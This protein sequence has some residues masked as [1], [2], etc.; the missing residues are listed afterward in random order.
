MNKSSNRPLSLSK[1]IRAFS[2][3]LIAIGLLGTS[4]SA[5][6]AIGENLGTVSNSGQLGFSLAVPNRETPIAA[7]QLP[8][9]P[10]S[11]GLIHLLSPYRQPNSDYSAGHRGVDYRAPLA[12]QVFSPSDGLIAFAGQVATRKLVTIKHDANLVT[13]FEPVCSQVDVGTEVRKGDPI[14]AI[15]NDLSG[16]VWHCLEPCLHFSLRSDGKYLSPLVLIGGLSPSRLLPF[17]T[18]REGV[19]SDNPL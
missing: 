17:L 19:R 12:T 7:W 9:A 4:A 10:D 8:I 5:S 3:C 11:K 6:A 13:E 1:I 16:Y 15:C 18:K 2:A 14:G